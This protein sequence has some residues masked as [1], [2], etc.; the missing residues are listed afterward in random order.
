MVHKGVV[1]G[2][3]VDLDGATNEQSVSSALRLGAKAEE[4]LAR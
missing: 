1:G 3:D 2:G 4:E